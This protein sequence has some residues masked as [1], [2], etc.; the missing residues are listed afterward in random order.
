M[1]FNEF[2]RAF[3]EPMGYD[4]QGDNELRQWKP[5]R[6]ANV[7]SRLILASEQPRLEL[8]TGG[9]LFTAEDCDFHFAR[10]GI[11][12]QHRSYYSGWS[13]SSSIWPEDHRA[14]F[15]LGRTVLAHG[16]GLDSTSPDYFVLTIE[17]FSSLPSDLAKQRLQYVRDFCHLDPNQEETFTKSTTEYRGNYESRFEGRFQQAIGQAIQLRLS[18]SWPY[19]GRTGK[20]T[21][22]VAIVL[23]M[24]ALQVKALLTAA[25][26]EGVDNPLL[27]LRGC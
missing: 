16:T 24:M 26:N 3:D 15:S 19:L 14:G 22:A 21:T 8:C 9:L 23:A 18:R 27:L 2:A 20:T 25:S 11:E 6:F 10:E 4:I 7:K 13:S 12:L 5:S 17:L 1:D